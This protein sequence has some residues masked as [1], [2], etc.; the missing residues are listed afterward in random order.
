MEYANVVYWAPG[1]C[2]CHTPTRRTWSVWVVDL[3][4]PQ[5]CIWALWA[6]TGLHQGGVAGLCGSLTGIRHSG[7]LVS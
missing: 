1:P 6:A 2:F 5:W 3:N 4:T 7:V